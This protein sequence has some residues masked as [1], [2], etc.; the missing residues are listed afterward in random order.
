MA[1]NTNIGEVIDALERALA[2]LQDSEDPAISGDGEH[3]RFDHALRCGEAGGIA[4]AAGLFGV[5]ALELC[6]DI[7]DAW[8]ERDTE[9]LGQITEILRERSD[10]AAATNPQPRSATSLPV[11]AAS[12]AEAVMAR[13]ADD[14]KRFALMSGFAAGLMYSNPEPWHEITGTEMVE[15][16][17]HYYRISSEWGEVEA[18]VVDDLVSGALLNR[19]ETFV[20]D[21]GGQPVTSRDAVIGAYEADFAELTEWLR[22]GIT[23]VSR[24]TDPLAAISDGNAAERYYQEEVQTMRWVQNFGLR[25]T[26]ASE[27]SA[28]IPNFM[29]IHMAARELAAQERAG[30]TSGQMGVQVRDDDPPRPIEM[31]YWVVPGKL[32]AGEYPRNLDT[33]SSIVKLARLTD[34]G[35]SAFIDLTKDHEKLKPYAYLLNGPTHERF[36]IKDQNVPAT[37]ELTKQ[38]LDA[39]DRHLEAGRTVYVHCWGG[40]GRTGTIIGCWLS[41]HYEPGQAA[42]DRLRELWKKNPKS[43]WRRSPDNDLQDDYVREWDAKEVSIPARYQGCLTG[44]AVGT[45]VEFRPPGSFE[46]L[47]DMDIMRGLEAEDIMGGSADREVGVGKRS[48]VV[49]RGWVL[50][51]V[52]T[53]CGVKDFYR[54]AGR[55]DGVRGRG[56]LAAGGRRRR[57]GHRHRVGQGGAAVLGG[58]HDGDGVAAGVDADRPAGAAGHRRSVHRDGGG[59]V[60]G[61]GRHRDRAHRVGDQRAVLVTAPAEI[62]D[63][64]GAQGQPAE[65]GVAGGRQ[66]VGVDFLTRLITHLSPLG[67]GPVSNPQTGC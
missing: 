36:G 35:V 51:G 52:S 42:L 45:A 56:R 20:G 49:C 66:V 10:V 14:L 2:G 25:R 43:G 62:L 12:L 67:S 54:Q 4:A 22:S 64:G 11:L 39:I 31:S 13:N 29:G 57:P 65:P 6:D 27:Q 16:V 58:D 1:N 37:D 3:G 60:V 30:N 9:F 33:P 38:A 53:L 48:V 61:R 40:V 63:V 32:L 7:S 5:K 55:P 15:L 19:L 34:A 26:R 24:M 28:A 59:R 50:K 41:R 44:L 8:E 17:I 18:A 23:N 21:R 47:T 46:P